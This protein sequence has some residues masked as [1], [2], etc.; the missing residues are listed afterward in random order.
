MTRLSIVFF[1]LCYTVS[2]PVSHRVKKYKNVA[3]PTSTSLLA[4]YQ[5]TTP[6]TQINRYTAKFLDR[7]ILFGCAEAQVNSGSDGLYDQ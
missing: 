4:Q 5:E 3:G 2:I 7:T 1:L 6:I